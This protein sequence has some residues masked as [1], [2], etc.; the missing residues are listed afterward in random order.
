MH[1]ILTELTTGFSFSG[2]IRTD[3]PTFLTYHECP[4][5][6]AHVG[7]VA[8]EARRI[9]M[10]MGADPDAA[11]AAGWLHDISACFPTAD[12]ADIAHTLGLEVLPEEER[13]PLIVHQKLSGV[14]AKELF[15]VT[16]PEVLSAIECHTTLRANPSL[17]D[18][19]V[20]V[21]DKIE[22]DG[23]G[24]P[25]YRERLLK[26]LDRSLDDAVRFYLRYMWESGTLKVV[27]PWLRDASLDILGEGFEADLVDLV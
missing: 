4:R 23:V 5:T 1:P 27:H 24:I 12:R 3:A 6:A 7:M 10:L 9:A 11:E 17:L 16:N 2:E 26:A 25:P 21:A 13:F 14:L 19:V 8:Q 15:G 20:F 22:W 18:K